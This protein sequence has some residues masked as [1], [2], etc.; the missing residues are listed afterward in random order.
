A[1]HDTFVF[2]AVTVMPLHTVSVTFA[3]CV[4]VPLPPVIVSVEFPSGVPAAVV[5]VSVDEAV[6]GFGENV[7]VAP[8]GRPAT[9]NVTAPVKPNGAVEFPAA[10]MSIAIRPHQSDGTV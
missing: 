8:A 4:S 3:V 6:A 1:F 5:T 2:G 9:L 10:T 7:P